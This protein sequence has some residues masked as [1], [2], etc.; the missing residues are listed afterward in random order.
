M[1]YSTVIGDSQ[2]TAYEVVVGALPVSQTT[3]AKLAD[4]DDPVNIT[5]LSGKKFGA[6]YTYEVEAGVSEV[7][8]A[9]GADPDDP[10]T[11]L[12]GAGAY[13]T[14]TLST[15][16]EISSDLALSTSG[17]VGTAGGIATQLNLIENSVNTI[18]DTLLAKLNS[19]ESAVNALTAG[20][21]IT[22]V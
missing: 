6:M 15:D 14:L 12:S 8:V 22:P 13:A 1:A 9:T 19:L 2:P 17:S 5:L 4:V 21:V 18:T 3:A 7:V 16:V 10:W 11:K 20:N